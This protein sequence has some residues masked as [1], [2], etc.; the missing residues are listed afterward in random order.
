MAPRRVVLAGRAVGIVLGPGQGPDGRALPDV[1]EQIHV[2]RAGAGRQGV[3]LPGDPD[4][5]AQARHPLGD[6]R[7]ARPADQPPTPAGAS[8]DGPSPTTRTCT[9]AATSSNGPSASSSNGADWPPATTD[10]TYLGGVTLA[11]IIIHHHVR[12]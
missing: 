5:A 10:L 1:L 6:P 8:E 12:N 2:P 11:A 4:P 3:L 9:R 7:A